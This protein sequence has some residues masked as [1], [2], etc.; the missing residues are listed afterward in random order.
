MTTNQ[1]AYANISTFC[2]DQHLDSELASEPAFITYS[3]DLAKR[4]ETSY[5]ELAELVG[6]MG[7][8]LRSFGIEKGDRVV[9]YMAHS[10]ELVAAMLACARI[11]AVHSVI[12]AGFSDQALRIRLEDL[13]PK[14]L[15]CHD[16]TSRRGK[17][18]PL[19]SNVREAVEGLEFI[20][21]VVIAQFAADQ[22]QLELLPGELDLATELENQSTDCEP[23]VIAPDDLLFVLYTSGSTGKPKGIMHAAEGYR[24]HTV[25]T[26]QANLGLEQGV[27]YWCT[28]DPGWITGHS[29]VAYAPLILGTTQLIVQ[30][31]MDFP[32]AE[33]WLELLE[34]EQIQSFY[35]APTALRKLKQMLPEPSERFDLSKLTNIGSVG[36]PINPEVKNWFRD[37]FGNRESTKFV[38][39]WW[40][41]ETGGHVIVNGEP[42][43]G[44]ELVI[45]EG[46]LLIK[47]DWPGK[48]IGC[49]NNPDR[50]EQYFTT[51][52][53]FVTGD[54]AQAIGGEKVEVIGRA[55]DVLN[56][57]GHRLGTAELENIAVARD[58]VAEAAAIAVPDDITGQAVILHVQPT[59]EVEDQQRLMEQLSYEITR[60]I[61]KFALPREIKFIS[62][63]PKTRSGKIMRRLLR[64]EYLGESKGDVSTLDQEN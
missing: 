15:L 36:E 3:E 29:Y 8:L 60:G 14:V 56:I 1:T 62:K 5:S 34:R 24:Q 35:T 47:G 16:F 31:P 9:I 55:D 33:K 40:Q 20:D 54:L 44:L 27:K 11:G 37:H 42:I 61:G 13:E 41:T 59:A 6:R 19:A 45:D 63:L 38:D 26:A 18:V 25:A 30:G 49:W 57:S 50:F 2:L 52:G 12:F 7:N 58:D 43:P 21:Q 51:E 39:T 32:R 48:L 17:L 22:E 10:V 46:E 23:E 53:L 64:A 4:T 28:A